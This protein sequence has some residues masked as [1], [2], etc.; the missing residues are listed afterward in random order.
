M[1]NAEEINVPI[2]SG[3]ELDS[4]IGKET[5][6]FAEKLQ[7]RKHFR[8]SNNNDGIRFPVHASGRYKAKIK[9]QSNTQNNGLFSKINSIYYDVIIELNKIDLNPIEIF[10][11][12]KDEL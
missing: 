1:P 4:K 6:L 12:K 8:F 9:F 3:F 11:S 2:A 7:G 10:K 5:I